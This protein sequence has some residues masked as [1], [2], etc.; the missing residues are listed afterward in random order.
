[1]SHIFGGVVWPHVNVDESVDYGFDDGAA[2]VVGVSPPFVFKRNVHVNDARVQMVAQVVFSLT[3]IRFPYPRSLP[4][5][6]SG[7]LPGFN[8]LGPHMRIQIAVLISRPRPVR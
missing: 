3:T 5:P 8:Q 6:T 1:M 2:V 4:R 7:F